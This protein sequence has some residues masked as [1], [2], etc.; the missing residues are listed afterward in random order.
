M[1]PVNAAA[2]A[3]RE[4]RHRIREVTMMLIWPADREAPSVRTPIGIWAGEDAEDILV[5]DMVTGVA[6]TRTFY[7]GLLG[8]DDIT[9]AVGLEV[10][11]LGVSLSRLEPAVRVAFYEKNPRGAAAQLYTRAYDPDTGRPVAGLP[12]PLWSGFVDTAPDSRPEPGGDSV[13]RAGLVSTASLLTITS[14]DTKSD[15]AQRR[16]MGD[17]FRRYKSTT[18]DWEV[19]WEGD[20]D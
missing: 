15:A 16:R 6:T 20:R 11:S 5:Q 13:I 3:L 17:R 7:T 19:P 12:E 14:A 2:Q 4:Q 1:R 9:E 8:H 10:R 18:A